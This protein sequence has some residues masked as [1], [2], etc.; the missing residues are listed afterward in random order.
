[1]DKN[2]ETIEK[3][4]KEAPDPKDVKETRR[5]NAKMEKAREDYRRSRTA[6]DQDGA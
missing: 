1:M 5:Y 3:L 4:V 6:A 2:L